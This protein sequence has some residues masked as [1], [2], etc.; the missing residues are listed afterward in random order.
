M[1]SGSAG[2]ST[3]AWS[4]QIGRWLLE[5]MVRLKDFMGRYGPVTKWV[6]NPTSPL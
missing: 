1:F 3:D 5:V 6:S 2:A 4:D